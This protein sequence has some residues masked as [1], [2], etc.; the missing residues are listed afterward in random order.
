MKHLASA[1]LFLVS[2]VGFAQG[3]ISPPSITSARGP[4]QAVPPGP[5]VTETS[6][7]RAFSAS[8][9]GQVQSLYLSNGTVVALGP[10]FGPGFSSQVHQGTKI[11]I[12]GSRSNING[13]ATLSAQVVTLNQQNFTARTPPAPGPQADGRPVHPGAEGPPVPDA[14]PRAGRRGPA[15]V[16]G[17]PPPPPPCG[18]EERG[19]PAPP[20]PV[21]Q[22]APQPPSGIALPAPVGARTPNDAPAPGD[23]PAP[24]SK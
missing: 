24:P 15:L 23:A 22:G 19:R 10:D 12:V 3:P 4:G 7:I 18:R 1:A 8:P 6:R 21:A 20:P 16:A 14:G 17:G 9:D 11:R 5:S 13:Q 2:S